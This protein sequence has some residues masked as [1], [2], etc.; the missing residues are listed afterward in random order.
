MVRYFLV[1]KTKV[2]TYVIIWN[3]FQDLFHFMDKKCITIKTTDKTSGARHHKKTKWFSGYTVVVRGTISWLA[4]VVRKW[5]NDGWNANAVNLFH[6]YTSCFRQERFVNFPDALVCRGQCCQLIW[7]GSIVIPVKQAQHTYMYHFYI[8]EGNWSVNNLKCM[9]FVY[10]AH[11]FL[12]QMACITGSSG[13]E[14]C[15]S[16][17][18]LYFLFIFFEIYFYI[19]KWLTLFLTVCSFTVK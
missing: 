9:V 11:L 4:D 15:M 12:N 8:R 7:L 10:Q 19:D 13:W 3:Y 2:H 6:I 1:R 17:Q 14:I 16:S 5:L 18:N